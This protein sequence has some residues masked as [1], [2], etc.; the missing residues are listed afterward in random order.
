MKV[1][2]SISRDLSVR[3][4]EDRILV[5][6]MGNIGNI[7]GFNNRQEYYVEELPAKFSIIYKYEK[8]ETEL[9]LKKGG[10]SVELQDDGLCFEEVYEKEIRVNLLTKETNIKESE[11][12]DFIYMNVEELSRRDLVL[13]LSDLL[14]IFNPYVYE[15]LQNKGFKIG[16]GA[17]LCRLFKLC[18]FSLEG[19]E[20]ILK[21]HPSI[22]RDNIHKANFEINNDGDLSKV[23]EIPRFALEYLSKRKYKNYMDIFKAIYR[24]LGTDA[25]KTILE[26]LDMYNY[27]TTEM[28]K[29]SYWFNDKLGTS[30]K[31]IYSIL[32]EYKEYK[33]KA[34]LEYLMRQ[35]FNFGGFGYPELEIGL[36]K[37]Y[38]TACKQ[39]DIKAER[40][41][42]DL[43]QSHNV[44]MENKKLLD[45]KEKENIFERTVKNHKIYEFSNK[46]YSILA[47]NTTK[48]LV[49]EGNVLNHCVA[50]YVDRVISGKS[51]IFFIRKNEELENPYVT[52][53]L[54][55][56]NNMVQIRGKYNSNPTEEVLRFT[57]EWL[58]SVRRNFNGQ[59]KNNK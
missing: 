48:D 22:L 43:K 10:V 38:L 26:F 3:I 4:G 55:V 6:T 16:S 53:E 27:F 33:P 51:K 23:V 32:T 50:S 13:F 45:E 35:N 17:S 40:Y 34:L 18:L 2:K 14:R 41:P 7:F 31:N 15:N 58:K 52:C 49:Y 5:N 46:Q 39:V 9:I 20:K 1:K 44:V 59:D 42:S 30:I 12:D 37:D 54:D 36:M 19:V 56:M 29:D 24:D 28:Q 47:P 21:T 57:K 8:T 25:L 11:I